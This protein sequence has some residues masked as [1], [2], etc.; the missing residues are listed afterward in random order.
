MPRHQMS[1]PRRRVRSLG[2]LA[3][4]SSV[5]VKNRLNKSTFTICFRVV[6]NWATNV[7]PF[8]CGRVAAN[9][10]MMFVLIARE[11]KP[12]AS[13]WPGRRLL[14]AVD[15]VAWPFCLALLFLQVPAAEPLV[16]PALAVATLCAALRFCGAVFANHRYRFTT[17]WC[18]QVGLVLLLVWAVMKLALPA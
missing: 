12:D 17:W 1:V 7:I 5:D 10:G 8:S 11:P 3:D 16:R 18:V 4:K 14:A 15:A 6:P 13:P 9:G 2:F